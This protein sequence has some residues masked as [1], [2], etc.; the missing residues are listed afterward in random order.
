[1]FDD[2][3]TGLNPE[4]RRAV[5]ATDGPL[6][7]QA[8]AGS[9]KTK[10][11]THRIAY[12][13]ATRAASPQSILAVTFTNKAAREMRE[14]VATLLG[15]SADDRRFMPWMGTF[16]SICVRMLRIDGEYVGI[17]HSY[18]IFDETDRL[19]TIKRIYKELH[20]D[21]KSF[22]PRAISAQISSAKNDMIDPKEYAE[23]ASS[24]TARTTA[25]VYPRYQ[26]AL[27]EA[28]ALDFDDLIWRTVQLLQAHVEV[29]ERW[30]QRFSY[31]MIDEYQDTNA[32]QYTLIQLLVNTQRNLAVVGDDWQSIY[33]WRGADFRNILRFEADYKDCTVIKLEQNYRS[34]KHILDAAHGIIVRNTQRSEKQLWTDAGDGRKVQI[35]QV[36]SERAEAESI[37]RTIR[38]SVDSRLRQYKDFAV[39]YRTNA[40]SRSIE[41]SFIQYAV[42]YR[43]VGGVRFY[44]RKEIKD[45]IAYLRLLYQPED[46]TSFERVV[47][48]PARGIG[49]KSVEN[50]IGWALFER[51]PLSDAMAKVQQCDSL[52]PRAKQSLV[53]LQ[54]ILSSFR[55]QLEDLAPDVLL[56]SLVKRLGYMAYLDDKT[57]QGESRQE[58]VRELLGVAQGYHDTGLA[59]LLEEVAL[60]SDLDSTDFGDNVVTLMTLHAAKGLEFP[61]VFMAG[62]EESILP[63]SRALYDQSEMEEER[64]LCYVGMTRAREELYMLYA[65]SRSLYGG[66]L[67]NMPSRFLGEIAGEHVEEQTITPSFGRVQFDAL[68]GSDSYDEPTE[69]APAAQ[70]NEPR[71]VPD[72]SEGDTVKHQLFGQGTVVE[73]SGDMAA[74]YFK[75]KGLKKLNIAFAPLEKL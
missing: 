20:I 48:V 66:L 39:L 16:H 1:M 60:I 37:M 19:S 3:L 43:V 41:E 52:T 69:S 12:L 55:G 62:L 42:P 58:N 21:D 61:V 8:G 27:K 65:A 17:P 33:S 2:L 13:I 26:A 24:P 36:V 57:P 63:H 70:S 54:E 56:E 73:L 10:T 5:L 50:F 35:Q 30:K 67:H 29:R 47:N 49:A 9:G 68:D 71:Y 22:P 53:E 31:I 23:T 72:L 34:T 64:R 75:G 46:R 28:V 40:Q 32:A 18:V 15:Q 14:R 51:M 11:L 44:D 4:Q 6:L 25:E 7:I 45:L 74:I 59:T 38:I